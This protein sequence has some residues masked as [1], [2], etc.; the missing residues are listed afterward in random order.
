MLDYRPA[1]GSIE[2]QGFH[3]VIRVKIDVRLLYLDFDAQFNAYH[4]SVVDDLL[5]YDNKEQAASY[6]ISQLH[7][8]CRAHFRYHGLV[9]S[10][11][12]VY[13]MNDVHSPYPRG[14][15]SYNT[16]CYREFKKSPFS[17]P[18]N[19]LL[20]YLVNLKD[21]TK[22]FKFMSTAK[23]SLQKYNNDSMALMEKN[24]KYS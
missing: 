11:M 12:P 20:N 21:L 14:R 15:V 7:Q 2:N 16:T 4:H 22:P 19:Q 18:A 3:A 13:A 6:W 5:P 1:I 24:C 17:Y 8:Q 23:A 10:F 9:Y